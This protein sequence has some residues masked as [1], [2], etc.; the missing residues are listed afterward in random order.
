MQ[1][2]PRFPLHAVV[3][4][5]V[6][7]SCIGSGHAVAQDTIRDRG[8]QLYAD[9]CAECHGSTGQGVEDAFA[10]ALVGDLSIVELSDQIT[11]TMPEGEPELC[12]G[13]DARAVAA[14]IHHAFYSEEARIR[15]DPPQVRLSRLTGTQLRQSFAD[16]YA[17]FVGVAAP[18]EDRGIKGTYFDGARLS[19]DRQKIE[20]VDSSIDFDWQD[21]GPGEGINAKDFAIRWQGG[22][23]I[24]ETGRYEIVIR[25]TAAF[26]CGLGNTRRHFINNRVQSGDKS[27]FRKSVVLTAGR[28]YPL[29][30]D[31]YQ[32]KR[33]T[34][35][36]PV[37][38]S[39]SWIPPSGVEEVVPR[40]HLVPTY[41]RPAFSLQT[42]M[43]ADD[44]TYGFERGLTIDR[45]WDAA[46]TS[47]A[48]EFAEVAASDLWPEYQRRHKN[49]PNENRA[50]LRSFLAE[51][52][53]TAFRGPIDDASR[54]FYIDAQVDLAEDDE[55]A[56]RRSMLVTLKSPRF[57]YPG[58]DS[59]RSAS[60]RIANRL[61]L[62]LFDSLPSDSWFFG[63]ARDGHFTNEARARTAAVRMVK[64]NRAQAKTR[65]LF[66]EWLNLSHL[67]DI[68]KNSE[69]FPGFNPEVV[70]DQK[71]SLDAFLDKVVWSED[72]DF[73]QLFLADW[74]FTTPRLNEFYGDAWKPTA[75]ATLEF[76]QTANLPTARRGLVTHPYLMSGLAYQDST[77]PIH[78][79]VFLRRYILGRT[80]RPPAN[81]NFKPLTPDLA[82]DMTTRQ[83]VEL[84]TSPEGCRE[85]HAKINGLGFALENFDAV[86]RFR[87]RD[88]GKSVDTAGRYITRQGESV[89]F[90]GSTE[91]A[92]FL[93]TSDD[94]HRAF[95]KRAFQHLVKQPVAAY[96][97]N[98]LDQLT[99][100]FRKDNFNIRN[101]L[102][103]IAVIAAT[104]TTQPD[105]AASDLS[106]T[107]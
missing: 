21:K 105:T 67:G 62:T 51:I 91:L 36:P 33:K 88:D 28:V 35:Q 68:V 20:R 73:R 40:R 45:Q 101:L 60:Q 63:Q 83:R 50:R 49:D 95:V 46:T 43:P 29:Q 78:R 52:V 70:S 85:C 102:V 37:R 1:R 81:A 75:D 58:L 42:K 80:I 82:P 84:Q 22:L 97:T 13:D 4:L 17:H 71:A 56:I 18:T 24:D 100:N 25:S 9:Q 5:I 64:D 106:S 44:R 86:G 8:R 31:L 66:Y 74:S 92:E 27:E 3:L 38:I 14:F 26:T 103:E 6:G 104:Q 32:R 34:E 30:I 19:K 53:T 87:D 16:L 93:A 77:S 72:S 23:K 59:D 10:T 48:I 76:G 107:N 39:L 12:T 98:R 96:G 7:A 11:R 69:R 65:E 15:N 54:S 41:Q 61:A 2:T 99:E 89:S 47:S 55:E 94:V 57:L 90:K 79:G